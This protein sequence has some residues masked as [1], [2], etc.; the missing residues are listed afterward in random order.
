MTPATRAAAAPMRSE[1]L[2]VVN[3]FWAISTTSN[4]SLFRHHEHAGIDAAW[5][6][7]QSSVSAHRVDV[8]DEVSDDQACVVAWNRIVTV[9]LTGVVEAPALSVPTCDIEMTKT[10]DGH[11]TGCPVDMREG[12]VRRQ[13]GVQDSWIA[14]GKAI[15][16]SRVSGCR[17]VVIDE[18]RPVVMAFLTEW[19]ATVRRRLVV[20]ENA[21]VETSGHVVGSTA[22]IHGDAMPRLV[23]CPQGVRVRDGAVRCAS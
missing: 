5:I 19:W 6:A 2:R 8:P 17:R 22:G 9:S 3:R 7:R 16:P 10:D 13:V 12:A 14:N 11:R 1:P 20:P 4:S 23:H 21:Q 15:L 18:H